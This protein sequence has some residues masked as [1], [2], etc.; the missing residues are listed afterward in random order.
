MYALLLVIVNNGI[1]SV[2]KMN[3]IALLNNAQLE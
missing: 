3:G 1:P 2:I